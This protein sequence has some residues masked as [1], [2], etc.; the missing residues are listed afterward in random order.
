MHI[1]SIALLEMFLKCV[2]LY[3]YVSRDRKTLQRI[4]VK[5]VSVSSSETGRNLIVLR[6]TQV[7]T[8]VIKN[9]AD[10]SPQAIC[11]GG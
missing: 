11:R 8:L 7:E 2:R 3:K 10:P 5:T 9:A 4:T 1:R 6:P